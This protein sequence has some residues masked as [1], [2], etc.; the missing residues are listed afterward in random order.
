MTVLRPYQ[1]ALIERIDAAYSAGARRVLA[2]L[3]TG[4]GKTVCFSS[5]IASAA[6][7]RERVLILAHRQEIIDQISASLFR[8]GVAHGAIV[9][10]AR[11]SLQPVQVASVATL[12]RR[13]GR[14]RDAFGLIVVDEAHHAVAGSWRTILGA[15]ERSRVLGVTATPERLD[16]RGLGDMFETMIVGPGVAE[17]IAGGF[18]SRFR[19]FAPAGA[20]SLARVKTKMGDYALDGLRAAMGGAVITAAVTE[21]QRLAAGVPAVAFCVDR[22]HSEDV[23]EAFRAAGI[24]AAHVDGETPAGER[25]DMMAALGSGGL[26]VLCNCGL[27]SEG[28]DVPAIGAA[29]LLRP[30]QSLALNLQQ[31]GR[32][33]RMAPG[34]ESALILDF[35]GNT[36]RHGRPDDPRD[37]SL[38]STKR[39]GKRR[40]AVRRCRACGAINGL[41]ATMCEECGATLTQKIAHADLDV[42]LIDEET[43]ALRKKIIGM[44][45]RKRI[46]WAGADAAKLET[47]ASA[48]GY[49]RG[50][51]RHRL[52]EIAS[53]SGHTAQMPF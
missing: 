46:E 36:E 4:A 15:F 44:T 14:W 13:V 33:L 38:N 24:R 21:Y 17:L 8:H 16:G 37:W 51:V 41:S 18:L 42:R 47:V 43:A 22:G 12:A 11:E 5:M 25:R 1:S 2:V 34:K 50:W 23:A 45:Y 35:A 49:K 9:A 39:D 6:E 26:D 53:A 7:R 52:D 28:V 29:I 19:I 27:I 48:C 31:I 30:T 3:P 20:P 40:A 32:A 10:G